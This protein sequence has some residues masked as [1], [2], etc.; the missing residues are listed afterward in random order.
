MESS[1]AAEVDLRWP[2]GE[3][4]RLAIRHPRK[5]DT[6]A[7]TLA[8]RSPYYVWQHERAKM[9]VSMLQPVAGFIVSRES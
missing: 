9:S 7:T 4:L 3:A 5:P 8:I 6:A 2:D 1:S